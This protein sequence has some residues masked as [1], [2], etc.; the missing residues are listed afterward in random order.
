LLLDTS[1][2]NKKDYIDLLEQVLKEEK[3][4]ISDIVISHWHADHIGGLKDIRERKLV[5]DC[6]RVWKFPRNDAAENFD[7]LG[8]LKLTDEQTF[9]VDEDVFKIYHTPGH[10][11]D[12]AII[13]NTRK[14][15]VFSADCILGEGTAVF[16]DLYDYMRSLERIL[17]LKPDVIYPGHGNVID[18][19]VQKIEYYIAHRGERERQI[20]A[21]LGSAD[22]LTIMEIVAVVY[23]ESPKDLWKAAAFNVHHHLTKLV[24][25]GRVMEIKDGDD[26]YFKLSHSNKL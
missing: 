14:N 11:T 24:K 19:A 4:S 21:A 23:K 17:S 7:A 20:L 1:E 10:T 8:L 3:A 6:C 22:R 16:E 2:P 15:I 13:F 25:E 26:T 5:D 12:H 18:D 9:N